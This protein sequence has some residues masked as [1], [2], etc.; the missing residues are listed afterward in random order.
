MGKKG[1]RVSTPFGI[2]HEGG[3]V[4]LGTLVVPIR[5]TESPVADGEQRST[6]RGLH[7]P[8]LTK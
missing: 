1:T 8:E 5:C 7:D 4:C 6:T 3:S 2:A